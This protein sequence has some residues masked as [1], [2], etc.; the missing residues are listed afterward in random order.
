MDRKE[1]WNETYVKY[2]KEVTSEAN[3]KSSQESHVQKLSSGDYKTVGEES[4]YKTLNLLNYNESEKLLD[5]G[6]GFGRFFSFFNGKKVKYYG[7]DISEAM[8]QECKKSF[9]ENADCFFCSE[10]E[11]LPF[12]DSFFDKIVCY[13]VFDACYQEKALAEMLRVL[14]TDGELLITGKNTNYFNNDEQAYIA[15]EAA[16]KKG[17]PNY[18][19]DVEKMKN[20]IIL[21]GTG[22]IKKER[23]FKYR[24][25]TGKEKFVETMPEQFYEWQMII[26]KKTKITDFENFS[27]AYSETW[28]RKNKSK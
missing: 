3:D 14:K 15:E 7:I 21:T 10:G 27:D 19:T 20:A 5:Y 1:Y 9:S 25:D 13:G 22:I 8:I 4:A 11:D 2:W 28:K 6:C 18:F 12:D 26:Q 24:G 23:Y 16:R 17:H